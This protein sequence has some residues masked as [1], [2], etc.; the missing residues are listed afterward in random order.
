MR[1]ALEEHV[2][3]ATE[4]N[5]FRAE[6][7]RAARVGR[8]V[9]VGAHAHPALRVR[10]RHQAIVLFARLGGDQ[11]RRTEDHAARRAVHRDDLTRLTKRP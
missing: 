8:N 10:P 2:L 6:F 4:A 7:A 9:G 1:V 5:A 11:L 3:R